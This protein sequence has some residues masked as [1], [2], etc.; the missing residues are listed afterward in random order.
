MGTVL[1][2]VAKSWLQAVSAREN[3]LVAVILVTER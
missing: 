3:G 2:S 1:N